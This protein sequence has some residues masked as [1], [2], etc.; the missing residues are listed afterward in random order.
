MA[1]P[2]YRVW[3]VAGLLVLVTIALYWPVTGHDFVN[4]DDPEYVTANV[5]VQGGLTW[6]SVKWACSNTVCCNWHPLTVWSHMAGL[7]TVRFE[8]LGASSNQ[9]AAARA[10]RCAGL[11]VAA[12]DDRRDVAERGGSGVVRPSPVACRIGRLGGRTQGCAQRVLWPAIPSRL[13]PIRARR[14]AEIRSPKSEVRRKSEDRSPKSKEG[15]APNVESIARSS[16]PGS[17]FDVRPSRL[18]SISHLLSSIFYPC[19]SSPWA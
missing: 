11:R 10:Q 2:P 18:S 19:S 1:K 6:E 13:C 9:R 7:P 16:V 4:L 17:A 8:A 5:H 12:T 3:L 14:G 15:P